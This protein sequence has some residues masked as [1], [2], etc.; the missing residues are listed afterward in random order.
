MEPQVKLTQA[1]LQQLLSYCKIMEVEGYYYGPK[2]QFMAR[3]EKIKQW[4]ETQ[5]EKRNDHTEA[6]ADERQ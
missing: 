4:I 1:Q 2:G 6:T 5:L 3:H